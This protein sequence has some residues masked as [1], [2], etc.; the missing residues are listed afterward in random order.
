MMRSLCTNACYF[1]TILSCYY[2]SLGHR[3]DEEMIKFDLAVTYATTL[4][5]TE[6][7]GSK[8]EHLAS[9]VNSAEMSSYLGIS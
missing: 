5:A 7:K 9:I 8:C 1:M 4:M 6:A 3:K 2:R